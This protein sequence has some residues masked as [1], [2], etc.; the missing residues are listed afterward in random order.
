MKTHTGLFLAIVLGLLI[1]GLSS[2]ANPFIRSTQA[3]V[4][5]CDADEDTYIATACQG[6]D[7]NDFDPS[8]HP[9]ATEVCNDSQDNDCDGDTDFQAQQVAC[10]NMQ[11][12]WLPEDCLCSQAT[13]I[14][15]DTMGNGCKLTD[16]PRGVNFDINSDGRKERLSWTEANTDEAFLALDRNGNGTIDGGKE[17]FGN[18]TS[19]PASEEPNGFLALAEFDKPENGGNGDGVISAGDAVFSSLLLWE[20]ANHN[21][22]SEPSEIYKLADYSIK[23]IELKYRSSNK[24]DAHGNVFRY[25]AKVHDSRGPSVGRWLWDVVLLAQ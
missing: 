1:A 25:R 5:P 2:P 15:L 12:V 3:N 20:D 10:A 18:F 21:G 6:D 17:L 8:I 4:D 16:A 7:C 22:V 23:S 11:W 9:G 13:P 19:Q 14:I 24:Q